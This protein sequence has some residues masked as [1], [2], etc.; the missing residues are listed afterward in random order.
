MRCR[1]AA[2]GEPVLVVDRGEEKQRG[3]IDPSVGGCDAL[4]EEGDAEGNMRNNLCF[5]VGA[6]HAYPG[7]LPLALVA[8][9]RLLGEGEVEGKEHAEIAAW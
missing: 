3:S 6:F 7:A 2:I 8:E 9:G 4:E 5:P 1:L